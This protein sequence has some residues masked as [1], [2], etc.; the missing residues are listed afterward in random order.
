MI[1][2]INSDFGLTYETMMRQKNILKMKHEE[3][4]AVIERAMIGIFRRIPQLYTD[5][6]QG[7][8]IQDA[9]KF[10]QGADPELIRNEAFGF[11]ANVLAHKYQGESEVL[12]RDLVNLAIAGIFKRCLLDLPV[13]LGFSPSVTLSLDTIGQKKTQKTDVTRGFNLAGAMKRFEKLRKDP[14][15]AKKVKKL[16][17]PLIIKRI[18][19]SLTAKVTKK[20]SKYNFEDKSNGLGIE[21]KGTDLKKKI[22]D[23]VEQ[24]LK[25]KQPVFSEDD[26]EP[27][28]MSAEPYDEDAE[29]KEAKQRL[30]K[31]DYETRKIVKEMEKMISS[32]DWMHIAPLFGFSGAPGV[33]S[34]YLR[35]PERKFMIMQA[36]RADQGPSGAKRYLEVFRDM[37]ENLADS[38]I[39]LSPDKPGVLDLMID[40][41][42]NKGSLATSDQQMIDLLEEMRNN[43]EDLSN[44]YQ[45][46]LSY[47]ELEEKNPE[48]L[49]RLSRTPGGSLLR[50][51]IGAVFDKIIKDMDTKWHSEM[52]D[53]LQLQNGLKASDADRLA[54]YFTGL[55]VKPSK[56]DFTADK[57]KLSK[58]VQEFTNVGIEATEF[59][60]ALRYSQG[61]FFSKLDKELREKGVMG[62]TLDNYYKMVKDLTS[63]PL[64]IKDKKS[65]TGF[66]LDKKVYKIFKKMI[67]G[68]NGAIASYLDNLA[69]EQFQQSTKKK[70]DKIKSEKPDL[71]MEGFDEVISRLL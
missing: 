62:Q 34:W 71:F 48:E 1:R 49:R 67:E 31:D 66:K 58:T 39:T 38:L 57:D 29:E 6:I 70:L 44:L 53:Y 65:K 28:D 69:I 5:F 7:V 12:D 37:R 56:G 32:G 40:E 11:I 68:K 46:S 14:A 9:D 19:D 13:E 20:G 42:S 50:F 36:A 2:R 3:L 47:E 63:Q 22:K 43:I 35:Y 23:Y 8:A 25:G 26:T 52:S 60:E 17:P 55:K 64:Y 41:I 21:V 33:R 51:G 61:W 4:V 45:S 30:A 59:F 27:Q 10:A 18:T 15:I 54:Y 24:M 16:M